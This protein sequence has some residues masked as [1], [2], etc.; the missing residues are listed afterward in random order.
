MRFIDPFR[1]CFCASV[2]LPTTSLI[3]H[4]WLMAAIGLETQHAGQTYLT[5]VGLHAHFKNARARLTCVSA[6]LQG[7][8]AQTA[9]QF[10]TE[11]VWKRVCDHIK[12]TI[13]RFRSSKS[14]SKPHLASNPLP[15][16][17]SNCGFRLIYSR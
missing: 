5:L 13:A 8:F 7:W 6:L 2:Y 1:H 4:P 16:A 15:L 9:E 17:H 14:R 11:A 10:R 3:S 12:L